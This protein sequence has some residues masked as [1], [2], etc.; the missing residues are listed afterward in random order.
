MSLL[1][2]NTRK[3]AKYYYQNENNLWLN[4]ERCKPVQW[5]DLNHL[6]YHVRELQRQKDRKLTEGEAV[7]S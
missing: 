2:M 6:Y 5:K 4:E 7:L 3:F 1:H